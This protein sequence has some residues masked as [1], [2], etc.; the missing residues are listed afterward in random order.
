M[1]LGDGFE[2]RFDVGAGVL[3]ATPD[4]EWPAYA[5]RGPGRNNSD[6]QFV[7]NVGPI[8]A[9]QYRITR[10]VPDHPSPIT[11]RCTPSAGTAQEGRSGFLIHGD[12]PSGDASEG[13]I[14]VS[15]PARE[16]IERLLRRGPVWLWVIPS[17]ARP[18][19]ASAKR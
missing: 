1:T 6:Y 13:C 15:R 4:I 14:I 12:N 7:R 8:P 19:D 11:F 5:G 17:Q 18:K 10:R 16:Y 2:L 3:R 9:G